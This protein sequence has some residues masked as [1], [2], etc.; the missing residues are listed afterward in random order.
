MTMKNLY[1]LLAVLI[2][3]IAL[4]QWYGIGERIIHGLWQWFKFYGYSNNGH[5]TVN[6]TSLLITS[7]A[8]FT[9]LIFYVI[10]YKFSEDKFT[11]LTVRFSSYSLALGYS[12]LIALLISPIGF[13]VQR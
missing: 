11:Q 6:E 8:T 4:I 10:L 9:T 1:K 12:S 7:I 13:L 5:T 3:F 2:C